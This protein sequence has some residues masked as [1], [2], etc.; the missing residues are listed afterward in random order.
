MYRNDTF[1]NSAVR[2]LSAVSLGE[3]VDVADPEN[4]GRVRV[5]V[6]SADGVGEQDGTVWARVAT[7]FAGPD[8]G[9]YFLP[10]VG[11]QVLLCFLHG[12]PRYPVVVGSLWHGNA[13]PP[14]QP[15]GAGNRIDRWTMTGKAGTRIAM[16]EENGSSKIELKTAHGV[17]GEWTDSGGGAVKVVAGPATITVNSS[18][19]KIETPATVSVK[20]SAVQV[21][22]PTVSVKAAISTFQGIVQCDVLQA[23]TVIGTTYTPGVGNIW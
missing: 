12:D 15:G 4:I 9:A 1:A 17:R 10:D 16:V 20:A 7:P 6:V 19:V 21:E 11:D 22:A 13:S 5:R 18:G 8:Y 3:V 14:E 2:L 23:T